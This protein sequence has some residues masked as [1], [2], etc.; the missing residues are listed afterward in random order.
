MWFYCTSWLAY[1]GIV[2]TPSHHP[3]A[4]TSCL[5]ISLQ[6]LWLVCPAEKEM[7]K[8]TGLA[9]VPFLLALKKGV[10]GNSCCAISRDL[11]LCRHVTRGLLA[12]R[13]SAIVHSPLHH[14]FACLAS[15][16]VFWICDLILTVVCRWFEQHEQ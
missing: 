6:E 3:L 2:R 10:S 7:K 16:I 13:I 9:I 4:R 14:V 8:R 15:Q 11:C 5:I 12:T 1:I